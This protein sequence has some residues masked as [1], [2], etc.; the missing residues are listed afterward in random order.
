MSDFLTLHAIVMALLEYGCHIDSV[1][2]AG[3]T[4]L[5]AATTGV[6]DII[7]RSQADMSLKCLAAQSVRK[8]NINYIGQVSRYLV[9][10]E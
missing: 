4:P 5:T 7:L 8:Y 6:A 3:Q 10:L 2:S 1:N 9:F